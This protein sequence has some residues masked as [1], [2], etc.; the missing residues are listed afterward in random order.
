MSRGATLGTVDVTL[1][2]TTGPG[3]AY[4]GIGFAGYGPS[5]TRYGPLFLAPRA[6]FV[7]FPVDAG[8][9]G[10]LTLPVSGL[11]SGSPHHSLLSGRRWYDVRFFPGGHPD[12][13]S[14]P[15]S[16]YVR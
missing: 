2:S 1:T 15:V 7:S 3:T 10:S 4:L 8:G 12:E 11:G 5:V 13:A 6:T 16:L 14:N 9:F